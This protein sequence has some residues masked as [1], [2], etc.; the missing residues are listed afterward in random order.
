MSWIVDKSTQ[1]ATGKPDFETASPDT[2][3]RTNT[4]PGEGAQWALSALPCFFAFYLRVLT[5]V[6]EG[7]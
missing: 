2:H 5:A 3:W 4:S 1:H 6:V 7:K